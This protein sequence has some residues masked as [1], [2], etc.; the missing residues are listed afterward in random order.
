MNSESRKTK[1]PIRVL[2]VDDSLLTLT[3]LQRI[4]ARAP[5]IQVVGTAVNGRDALRLIPSLQPDVI[6]TD[7]HMPVMDGLEFTRLVM[8]RFPRPILV[9]SVSV[10]D[11]QVATIFKL[12]EAGAIDIMPKPLGAA[13]MAYELD[14]RELI[15]KITILAGVVTIRKRQKKT[16]A[17]PSGN[18]IP[19]RKEGVPHVI[20]IGASTGGP[21]ALKEILAKLPAALPVPVICVQH[22]SAD[23]M[24]GLVDWLASQCRLKV[25]TAEVGTMPQAGRVYFPP[26]GSHLIVDDYGRLACA[27]SLNHDSPCPSINATFSS[28]ARHYGNRAAGVLLTGMGR[29]GVEGMQAIA[30]AGGVTIAQDEQSSIVFGMPKEAIAA[31]AARYV[32]PLPEIASAL[33]KLLGINS[34]AK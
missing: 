31:N 3:V 34:D 8:E 30:Q 11:G 27:D 20:G 4:L 15:R 32:L 9:L 16:S 12:L 2:L 14:A 17:T 28:L 22:I 25:M 33:L 21:Q 19:L 23:F 10:Q 6:C 24:Q 13:G 18:R 5:E 1:A 29:D 7:L 26:S